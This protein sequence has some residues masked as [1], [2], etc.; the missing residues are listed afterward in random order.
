MVL[1]YMEGGTLG[2]R[3]RPRLDLATCRTVTLQVSPVCAGPL[4]TAV[5]APVVL[6]AIAA[7]WAGTTS[8]VGA[9]V[10]TPLLLTTIVSVLP[11]TEAS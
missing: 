1:E 5:S 8:A 3:L 2:E 10:N 6:C 9:V 11:S 4:S 7:P